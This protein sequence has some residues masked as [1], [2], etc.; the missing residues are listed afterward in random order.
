MQPLA[1]GVPLKLL[2]KAGNHDFCF[3]VVEMPCNS[4]KLGGGGEG[5]SEED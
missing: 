5:R 2:L 4:G 1:L 3:Y